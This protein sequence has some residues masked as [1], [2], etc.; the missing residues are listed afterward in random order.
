M[1]R[2]K[3]AHRFMD[4]A[5]VDIVSAARRTFIDLA[6]TQFSCGYGTGLFQNH[7]SI[8]G[9]FNRRVD[10]SFSIFTV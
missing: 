7:L 5:L 3:A 10:F 9:R 2:G 1:S 4:T 8:D 6:C